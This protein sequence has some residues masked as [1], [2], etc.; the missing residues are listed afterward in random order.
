MNVRHRLIEGD[1]PVDVA[2]E[3]KWFGVSRCCYPEKV[4]NAT[5]EFQLLITNLNPDGVI[6]MQMQKG[7]V[8]TTIIAIY[9]REG[10]T[11]KQI[12]HSGIVPGSGG[13]NQ[14]NFTIDSASVAS[15]GMVTMLGKSGYDKMVWAAY[16]PWYFKESWRDAKMADRPLIG[17]YASDDEN[18]IRLHIR[19][20]K[21]AGIDGFAVS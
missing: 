9:D 13:R 17:E 2:W 16:Y 10:R 7:D 14:L 12:T 18:V 15:S 8:G 4:I 11:I 5:V 3:G 21:A 19:M 6:R 1:A 20:A